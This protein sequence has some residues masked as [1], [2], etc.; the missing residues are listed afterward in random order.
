MQIA[1]VALD[2][3]LHRFFDY[4][5]PETEALS[6]SDLG[7]LVRVPF[8]QKS[9]IG[10]IVE[11]PQSSDLPVARLKSIEAVLRDIPALPADWFRLSEFLSLIHISEPTRPY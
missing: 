5:V 3:P 9:R 4:I 1:R 6:D 11:L 10:I 8:G 2:V 7:R